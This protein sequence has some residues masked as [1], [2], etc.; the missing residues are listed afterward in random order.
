MA[1]HQH[2]A[3]VNTVVDVAW[4]GLLLRDFLLTRRK[5]AKEIAALTSDNERLEVEK[6]DL[7]E[8]LTSMHEDYAA[9][10]QVGCCI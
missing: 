10:K 9:H 6:Q 8:Q 7:E 2:Q 1:H 4:C 3:L 5:R